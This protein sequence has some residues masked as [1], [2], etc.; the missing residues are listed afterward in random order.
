MLRAGFTLRALVAVVTVGGL[1][2]AV[3]ASAGDAGLAVRIG[4]SYD[5]GGIFSMYSMAC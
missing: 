1:L 4:G 2:S 3:P 5:L